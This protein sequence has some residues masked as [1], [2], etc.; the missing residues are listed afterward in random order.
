MT[1]VLKKTKPIGRKLKALLKKEIEKLTPTHIATL[2]DASK[3]K[4]S[5]ADLELIGFP[6]RHINILEKHNIENM[7]QLM[8]AKPHELLKIKGFGYGGLINLYQCLYKYS[9][10]KNLIKHFEKY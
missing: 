6:Y 7:Q 3:N 9:D 2:I 10:I 8:D 5:I 4:E 1:T